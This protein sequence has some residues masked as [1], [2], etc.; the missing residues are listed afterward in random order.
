MP[1]QKG[2]SP[3]LAPLGAW[4]TSISVSGI[5]S[6]SSLKSGSSAVFK[7]TRFF[8]LLLHFHEFP[9]SL[10][11]IYAAFWMLKSFLWIRCWITVRQNPRWPHD[12]EEQLA[13]DEL[14]S[15][16]SSGIRVSKS[17]PKHDLIL[18]QAVESTGLE[19][20][21]KKLALSSCNCKRCCGSLVNGAPQTA[22]VIN[23]IETKKEIVGPT[24]LKLL[25][26]RSEKKSSPMFDT[27][28][29]KWLLL[30]SLHPK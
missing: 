17:F 4:C 30:V 20:S 28:F 3:C 23:V 26:S 11:F 27:F 25:S 22:C 2:G 9:L 24:F 8:S 18:C 19:V 14:D 1:L 5:P 12:Y 10:S 16:D 15:W 6:A 29:P 13:G 7:S 21:P